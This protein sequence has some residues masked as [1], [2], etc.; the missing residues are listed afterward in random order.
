V[1]FIDEAY[2]LTPHSDGDFGGEAVSTLV[3][4]M[5]EHRDRLAVIVAGYPDEMQQFVNSNA[6]LRSRFPRFIAFPD[7]T[8]T[9]LVDIFSELA[10]QYQI[11]IGPEVAHRVHGLLGTQPPDGPRGNA[12]QVRN[13][14][15]TAFARMAVRVGELAYPGQSISAFDATDIPEA[16]ATPAVA[17]AGYI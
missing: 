2:A 8:T 13:L 17:A 12:R 9:E 7:Y 5:E 6:G 14:F 16:L 3:K 15:E 1:L 4:L 10:A 11:T